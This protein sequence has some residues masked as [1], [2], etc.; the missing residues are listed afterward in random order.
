MNVTTEEIS[1]IV[2]HTIQK[3]E[4][5]GETIDYFDILFP[6]ELNQYIMRSEINQASKKAMC[7]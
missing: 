2:K 1:G 5:I 4:R 7:N 6:D 3:I